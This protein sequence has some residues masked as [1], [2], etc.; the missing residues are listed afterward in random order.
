MEVAL[1]QFNTAGKKYYFSTNH[2]D[3]NAEDHVV[4]ETIRGMEIGKVSSLKEIENQDITQ[5]IKPILRKATQQDIN[6]YQENLQ[7]A[8]YVFEYTKE[9]VIQ[10]GLEMKIVEASYTLDRKKLLISFE[11]EERIDFRELV[12]SLSQQYQT[13]IELR[14]IGPRDAAKII[15]GIGPCG[16]M[17][18]CSTFIGEF[19]TISIKMAKNQNLSL[20]PQK[21]SGVCGKLLCCIKYEDDVYSELKEKMPDVS[22]IIQTQEGKAKV[23]NINILGQKVQVKYLE[24]ERYEWLELDQINL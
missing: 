14:Q 2:L 11:A 5:E 22:Q 1:I 8:K 9:L 15:G 16:L 21:I 4:V 10:M 24:D 18:C 20:N 6:D 17:L 13:R 3:L 12:R 19:D 7:L 23:V